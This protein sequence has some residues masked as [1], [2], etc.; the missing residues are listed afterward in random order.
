[1]AGELGG[2]VRLL[3]R[4]F[5]LV[6]PGGGREVFDDYVLKHRRMAARNEPAARFHIPA[7]GSPYPASSLPAQLALKGVDLHHPRRGDAYETALF[8][9]F[10]GRS[11]D[12]S[13]PGV[14]AHCAQEAGIDPE[15]VRA[16]L[17]DGEIERRVLLEHREAVEELGVT[18]IPTVVVPGLPPIVG[19]VPADFYREAFRAALEG[20]APV[21]PGGRRLPTV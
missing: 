15:E 9:A 4:S 3:R 7:P 13:D 5:V 11:E 20:R 8:E 16:Y 1:M 21:P 19:A 14:L 2:R 10:F 12:V 18:G 6:P 17:R